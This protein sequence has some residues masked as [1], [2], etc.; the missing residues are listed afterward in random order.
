MQAVTVLFSF[1]SGTQLLTTLSLPSLKVF[2]SSVCHQEF[3]LSTGR[4]KPPS[5]CRPSPPLHSPMLK[6][7]VWVG[8]GE[9][10]GRERER[11]REGERREEEREGE[12]ERRRMGE[13]FCCLLYKMHTHHLQMYGAVVAFYEPLAEHRYLND[14]KKALKASNEVH[15][16]Q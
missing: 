10:E 1:P 5:H 8:E 13:K 6:D 3:P 4:D 11:G 15:T 7:S 14:M 16:I 12:R 2:P 9:R